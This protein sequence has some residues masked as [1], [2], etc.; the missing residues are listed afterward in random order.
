[1]PTHYESD[2]IAAAQQGDAAAIETLITQAQ[3]DLKRFAGRV[4]ATPEDVED[5]V[6]ETLWTVSRRIGSLR[7]ASAF[8][9]WAFRVV[10]HACYRLWRRVRGEE[11]LDDAV[12][13]DGLASALGEAIA[14][15]STND[16]DLK[17]DITV[18]LAHLPPIYRQVLILR[19][20]QEFSAPEVA[21]QL[22]LTVEVVKSRLHR[23]RA[24]M[25]RHLREWS[26]ATVAAL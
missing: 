14:I 5:A 10:T 23:A 3:P 20:V 15:T 21:S 4:C 9:S 17:C 11:A 22:P 7:T 26:P 13:E 2:L 25:R 1:M 6:Q 12:L 19:D 16:V 8:V 24:M 18:A